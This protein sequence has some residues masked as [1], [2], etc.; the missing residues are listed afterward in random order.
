MNSE[1]NF[2]KMK[3]DLHMHGPISFHPYWIKVQSY[4]R[5]NLLKEIAD[6]CFNKELDF[7]AI[8]SATD[9]VPKY[10]FYNRF[11]CLA[12]KINLLPKEYN[13]DKL[14]NNVLVV[15]KRENKVYIINSGSIEALDGERK[16]EHLIVGTN[17]VPDMS[18]T[19][20]LWWG[21][22]NGFIQIAEHP[23]CKFENGIGIEKLIK[24]IKHYDAIEGHNSELIFSPP[25][26]WL[27]VFKSFS[28][29]ANER[30]QEV[31]EAYGKPWVAVS[32]AHWIEH[33]GL[34]YIQFSQ[35]IDTSSDESIIKDLRE[36]IVSGKFENVCNY[37]PMI[38]WVGWVSKYM[39]GKYIKEIE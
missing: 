11:N 31:A 15:E 30:V 19:D 39:W 37:E 22:D 21:K 3:A 12:D 20:I 38:E 7:C 10:L 5:K 16:V 1:Q 28:R 13:A 25:L 34:S 23:E 27:P 35:E 9:D 14:G 36:V 26:S 24:H 29:K 6:S 8:T 17:Q 32:D 2:R 18:L 4:E 33:A